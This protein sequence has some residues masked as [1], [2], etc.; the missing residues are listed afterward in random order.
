MFVYLYSIKDISPGLFMMYLPNLCMRNH[1]ERFMYDLLLR[2][3]A[4]DS[5]SN[6]GLVRLMVFLSF[7]A[8]WRITATPVKF[9][10]DVD[11]LEIAGDSERDQKSLISSYPTAENNDNRQGVTSYKS[12]SGPLSHRGNNGGMQERYL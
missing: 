10:F 5:T 8:H 2:V 1:R 9:I 4:V 11:P 12:I 7:T 3:L 6:M